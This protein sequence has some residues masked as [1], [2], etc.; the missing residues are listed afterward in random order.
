MEGGIKI[1][2]RAGLL[3]DYRKFRDF[4]DLVWQ[5]PLFGFLV[6][7]LPS[8]ILKAMFGCG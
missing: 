3:K 5:I 1:R 7:S 8:F 2:E 4:Y 6:Y